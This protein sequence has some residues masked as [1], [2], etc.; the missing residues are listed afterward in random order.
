MDSQQKKSE[1]SSED[2][3]NNQKIVNIKLL[4]E[5]IKVKDT[6]RFMEV[7]L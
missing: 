5:E 1:P 3:K 4:S 6:E 2:R 7:T